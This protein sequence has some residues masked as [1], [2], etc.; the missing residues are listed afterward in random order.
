MR[1]HLIGKR[2]N[3]IIA[4]LCIFIFMV[5]CPVSAM[6]NDA[7][8][9]FTQSIVV[10]SFNGQ[11]LGNASHVVISDSEI[12]FEFNQ[13][14]FTFTIE[15]NMES[16]EGVPEGYRLY[17]GRHNNIHCIFVTNN[18]DWTMRIVNNAEN[19]LSQIKDERTN[20]TVLSPSFER[21]GVSFMQRQVAG[22]QPI[23]MNKSSAKS[24]Q[25]TCAP[26]LHVLALSDD[27]ISE[28]FAKASVVQEDVCRVYDLSY[29]V[30]QKIPIDGVRLFHDYAN[31]KVAFSSSTNPP[32]GIQHVA[33]F[34]RYIHA[35]KGAFEASST[36]VR[37]IPIKEY[38][39]PWVYRHFDV[40]YMNG[41]HQ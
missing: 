28:G 40:S 29:I 17:Y 10:N 33:G 11:V 34:S 6:A 26:D 25:S 15:K 31:A 24:L 12:S 13:T 20:F 4:S 2:L 38:S 7:S 5:F 18:Q 1:I 9:D 30:E 21:N 22:Y 39:W 16:S 27:R 3:A 37:I 23:S 8:I 32:R 36:T 19:G 41:G 14:I 35:T